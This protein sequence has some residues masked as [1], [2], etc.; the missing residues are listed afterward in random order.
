[1]PPVK[2]TGRDEIIDAAFDIVR[3][4]GLDSLNAR[5]IAKRL[6]TSTQPVFS[7]FRNMD[8]VKMEIIKKA[9]LLYFEML[10]EE[11]RKGQY[12]VLKARGMGYVRFAKDERFLFRMLFMDRRLTGVVFPTDDASKE[13][14][15]ISDSLGLQEDK[16]RRMHALLWFFIH[17]IA[18]LI[19]TDS[20]ELSEDDV[21]QALTDTY[22][23]LK[24][25]FADE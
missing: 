4:E 17:G 25:R 14:G 8:E 15:I 9:S 18:S 13:I 22:L 5:C 2:K 20:L 10:D 3:K 23:A 19:V 1:M 24:A 21:S 16:S 12:P 6:G 11:E 7:N